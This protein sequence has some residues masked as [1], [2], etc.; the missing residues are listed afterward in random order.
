M[1]M[2]QLE[3]F[4]AVFRAG[5]VSQAAELLHTSQPSLSRIIGDLESSVGFQLFTRGRRGMVPTI[6]GRR[7]HEAVER[8]FV[9]IDRLRDTAHIIGAFQDDELSIG[10]IPS[11]AQTVLPEAISIL[12]ERQPKQRVNIRV[13]IAASVINTVLLNEVHVGV[14]SSTYTLEDVE[15]LFR[16]EI[17]G[18]CLVPETHVLA[19]STGPI[20]LAE[21]PD[22]EF[23]S[24][25]R[26][27]LESMTLSP[28]LI[29]RMLS[30]ATILSHSTPTLLAVARA[31]SRLVIVDQL[32]AFSSPPLQGFMARKIV[33]KTLY[34]L[35]IIK[36]PDSDLRSP[37]K[38]FVSAFQDAYKRS[39]AMIDL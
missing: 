39:C 8:S 22:G 37:A 5:S 34:G 4:R 26:P 19:A 38:A 36:R 13:G 2:R 25:D 32:T 3:V 30:K 20:D 18:V 16:A 31:T 29:D 11:V 24:H 12:Q 27:F 21:L 1:N 33:Q 28:E 14:V 9:G 6:E 10:V 15:I 17:S 35:N 7:F 23:V